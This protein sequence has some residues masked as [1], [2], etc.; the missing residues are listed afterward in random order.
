MDKKNCSF[1]FVRHVP[2]RKTE[3][4]ERPLWKSL[5]DTGTK[6]D[7]F[8]L[9]NCKS[10]ISHLTLH[11]AFLYENAS[12]F[13]SIPRTINSITRSVE[14]IV[15]FLG[16][17]ANEKIETLFHAHDKKVITSKRLHVLLNPRIFT[18]F[19]VFAH[20]LLILL[21][22]YFTLKRPPIPM[23]LQLIK[24]LLQSVLF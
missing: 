19:E 8:F 6:N 14:K 9:V 12:K 11:V 21:P 4:G 18:C 24:L 1:S 16:L 20:C 2:E 22:Q 10:V 13:I 5:A 7:F 3:K 17:T 15:Q 23:S